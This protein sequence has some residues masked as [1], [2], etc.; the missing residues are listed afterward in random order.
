MNNI[1]LKKIKSLLQK[2][3]KL[4]I[5]K[6][7]P[8]VLATGFVVGAGTSK[9]EAA[10][11]E[12]PTISISYDNDLEYAKENNYKSSYV[13]D[14]QADKLENEMKNIDILFNNL[15]DKMANGGFDVKHTGSKENS[16]ARFLA[17]I[18]EINNTI[19]E[20]N[21]TTV[22]KQIINKYLESKTAES[23]L[24]FYDI[25][26][27]ST[28]DL[29][30]FGNKKTCV[31]ANSLDQKNLVNIG[32]YEIKNDNIV[33][34]EIITIDDSKLTNTK[35]LVIIPEINVVYNGSIPSFKTVYTTSIILK[36]DLKMYNQA[37]SDI[38]VFYSKI[39]KAFSEGNYKKKSNQDAE[40]IYLTLYGDTNLVSQTI[41]DK[42]K[43]Y[44][45]LSESLNKYLKYK[46]NLLASKVC[47][48]NSMKYSDFVKYQINNNPIRVSDDNGFVYYQLKNEIIPVID[49]GYLKTT[50]LKSSVS[51][52]TNVK[53]NVYTGINIYVDGKLYS[54]EP[55]NG[56]VGE[57][58]VYNGT[59]YLPVRDITHLYNADIK[60]ENNSV[61]ITKSTSEGQYYIDENGNKVYIDYPDFKESNKAP[62][63][64]LIVKQLSGVKGAKIYFNN[65][66]YTPQAVNGIP[67][68]VYVINGTT[69]LPVRDIAKMFNT[70]I[71]WDSKTNSVILNRNATLTEDSDYYYE[72]EYGNKHNVSE[73]DIDFGNNIINK[74]YYIDEN[75][76]K[77]YIDEDDYQ[78]TR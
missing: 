45:K 63:S 48:Q 67:A 40:D 13:T 36:S 31:F 74:P 1:D 32:I 75:G 28:K 66:L 53:L 46:Q 22:E 71:K 52:L 49:R 3:K 54:P 21:M 8:F 38:E 56:V 41:N 15:Y 58:F 68:D 27:I 76:N 51:Y 37:I 17:C 70:E 69:Y 25:T 73:D 61:I 39:E 33:N 65:V 35:S 59:T 42:Y 14:S 18:N 10:N 7:L 2:T 44:T 16:M 11:V 20:I 57:A 19:T 47:S 26:N 77:V 43:S 50:D 4:A 78:K 72:D 64:Q 30:T 60:W 23:K 34:S 62:S 55:L 9:A 29:T 6:A 5:Q 12:F 24:V